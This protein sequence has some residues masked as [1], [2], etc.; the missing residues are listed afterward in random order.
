[1]TDDKFAK[2][3]KA[4]LAHVPTRIA[5]LDGIIKASPDIPVREIIHSYI[6]AIVEQ[7][8][9][10]SKVGSA[11]EEYEE[12]KTFFIGVLEQGSTV[13]SDWDA[14]RMKE[15]GIDEAKIKADADRMMREAFKSNDKPSIH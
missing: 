4:A 6:I 8:F 2:L 9:N 14:D 3:F 13:I 15:K 1:M 12:Y 5:S 7:I 11:S 10:Q